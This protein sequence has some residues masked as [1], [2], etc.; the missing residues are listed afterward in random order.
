MKFF[1]HQQKIDIRFNSSGALINSKA[2]TK[3]AKAVLS[4]SDDGMRQVLLD[5][6]H[7][8]LGE[9][10]V[11]HGKSSVLLLRDKLRGKP[12]AM[13]EELKRYLAYLLCLQT[14]G[15]AAKAIAHLVLE[16]NPAKAEQALQLLEERIEEQS[17]FLESHG[18]LPFYIDGVMT[19]QDG[20][21]YFFKGNNYWRYNDAEG[22]CDTG[23]PKPI[24]EGW[25]GMHGPIDAVFLGKVKNSYGTYFFK[26]SSY[27]QYRKEHS[28]VSNPQPTENWGGLDG[29]IDGVFIWRNGVTYAFAEDSYYRLESGTF[30]GPF[31]ISKWGGM[32]GPINTVFRYK[33]DDYTY[34]FKEW[35]YY[36]FEDKGDKRLSISGPWELDHKWRGLC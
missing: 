25:G 20:R 14:S 28:Q 23:Y 3:W 34:F 4:Y 2:A 29:P 21:T 17:E 24:R 30:T 19:W 32:T 7:M 33:K 6:H 11:F 10:H 9:S 26:G 27:Y 8:I 5:F 1:L 12:G 36:K 22:K 18:V 35:K 15:H 13:C 16:H 31:P